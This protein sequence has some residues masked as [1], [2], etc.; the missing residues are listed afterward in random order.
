MSD[1][2]SINNNWNFL[3]RQVQISFK[4]YRHESVQKI[5]LVLNE[6]VLVLVIETSCRSSTSTAYG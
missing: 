5:G 2:A 4:V 6:M 3:I 1:K